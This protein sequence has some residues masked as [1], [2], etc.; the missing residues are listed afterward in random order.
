MKPD[1]DSPIRKIVVETREYFSGRSEIDYRVYP[2]HRLLEV[3][4]SLE[5]GEQIRYEEKYF[6]GEFDSYFDAVWRSIGC[7]IKEHATKDE[8]EPS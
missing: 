5:N 4:I 6:H 1:L 2:A 3:K 7:Q 8:K